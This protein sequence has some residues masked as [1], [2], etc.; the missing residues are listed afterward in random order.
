MIPTGFSKGGPSIRQILLHPFPA[1]QPR[2]FW[3][4]EL[5]AAGL[6]WQRHLCMPKRPLKPF[7]AALSK[8]GEGGAIEAIGKTQGVFEWKRMCLN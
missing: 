6:P 8:C 5:D 2:N 1:G 7:P 4:D 3:L